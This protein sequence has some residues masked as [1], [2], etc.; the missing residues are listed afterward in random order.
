MKYYYSS[1]KL[2]NN[3][4][5][6]FSSKEEM[7][8][9]IVSSWTNEWGIEFFTEEDIILKEDSLNNK[10]L[11]NEIF[12]PVCTKRIGNTNYNPPLNIGI[13]TCVEEE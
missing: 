2:N 12:Y 9:Y 6:E 8:K 7:I 5:G 3:V 11:N 13:C 10:S 4:Y 1:R